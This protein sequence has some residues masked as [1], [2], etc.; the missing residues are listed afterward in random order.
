MNSVMELTIMYTLTGDATSAPCSN[1]CADG[2]P[3]SSAGARRW[4]ASDNWLEKQKQ[5]QKLV[6][7][8]NVGFE[9]DDNFLRCKSPKTFIETSLKKMLECYMILFFKYNKRLLKVTKHC[10]VM[11]K[12]MELS[13]TLN[14][15]FE[16]HD[17]Q[18]RGQTPNY[19][20]AGQGC[21]VASR[22]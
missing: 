11:D 3:R 2:I 17:Q 20:Y 15:F 12:S 10:C 1:S 22:P 21:S 5:E 18:Q 4:L 14:V 13:R 6:G 9:R 19:R 16:E 7:S 8:E